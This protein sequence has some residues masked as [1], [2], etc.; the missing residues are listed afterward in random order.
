MPYKDRQKRKEYHSKY[1]R[2]TW[3]PKNKIIHIARVQNIKRR[4]MDYIISIKKLGR[5]ADCGFSGRNFPSVLDFHH[6]KDKKFNVAS[7]S[8]FV[9]SLETV[10]KEIRKCELICAN[11]HRIRTV[12]EIRRRRSSVG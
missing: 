4:T 10:K 9:V 5:C 6:L 1:M 7:F 11:C 12:K 8:R 3:Y 2:E